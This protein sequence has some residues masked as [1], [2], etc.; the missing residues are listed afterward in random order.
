MPIRITIPIIAI[1]L[2]G[3]PVAIISQ[4]TP[5]DAKGT[6]PMTTIGYS[7]DSKRLAMTKKTQAKA[8]NMLVAISFCCSRALMIS[9]PK[10]QL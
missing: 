2:N 7:N 10:F 1:M 4:K 9:L 8:N 6:V 5:N 3:V